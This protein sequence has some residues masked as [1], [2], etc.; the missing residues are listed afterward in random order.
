MM[1]Q[2]YILF[3]IHGEDKT[4]K[5]LR[6]IAKTGAPVY[7]VWQHDESSNYIYEKTFGV[8]PRSEGAEW[9]ILVRVDH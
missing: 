7:Y 9:P 1:K 2:Y 8:A 4:A 3:G 6:A 5:Y